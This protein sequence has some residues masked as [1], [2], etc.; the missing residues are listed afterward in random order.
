MLKRIVSIFLI[1]I[2]SINLVYAEPEFK[3][4]AKAALL[5]DYNTG[6]IIYSLNE[7]EELAP[8]SITKIMTLLLA[9]EAISNE[10]IKLNDNVIISEHASGMGGTQ[11]YLE[12]GE[13][14]T[15][16]NLIKAISIRSA[17][18]AA[19]ALAEHIAGTEESFVKM[20]NDKAKELGMENTHFSNASGLP[21][22]NLYTSAYD[23]AL[24][25]RE[26]LR[27][28]KIHDYLSTWMEDLVVG[29]R[30]HD[31]QVM[32][33]TNRL[34][35]DY[36]GANGI[37]TGS[38]SEA[39]YCVSASAKRQDLQL[40]AVIMGAPNGRVRFAEAKKLLDYGFANFDS[41]TIG[42]KGDIIASIPVE[43]G[44]EESVDIMLEKDSYVLVPKGNKVSVEELPEYPDHLE[45]PILR[46][47]KVGELVVKADGKEVDKIN[48][49]AKSTI[50]K[51]SI[52]TMLRKIIYNYLT[53]R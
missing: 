43:K 1:L 47:D 22:E 24:M 10:R 48:L 37:K 41:I 5:M 42:R 30:K 51:G 26:L 52:G 13:T 31:I 50:E 28:S 21:K 25:S 11:V 17:N 9:M 36:E 14:Q 34:I 35:K 45:A 39:G 7:K 16:E 23:V 20:M 15:V 18:D 38:T 19:V 4:D 2:L 6:K 27:H 29:K 46:G 12:P 3:I 44:R 49:I 32:V 8:A 33:N 53:G 40:I